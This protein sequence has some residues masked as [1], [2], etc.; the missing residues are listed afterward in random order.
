MGLRFIRPT[1]EIKSLRHAVLFQMILMKCQ[2]VL[3]LAW[4]RM[5]YSGAS[6]LTM[7]TTLRLKLDLAR[8]DNG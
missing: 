3:V 7:R 8:L 5:S 4:A 1:S 2:P 6:I